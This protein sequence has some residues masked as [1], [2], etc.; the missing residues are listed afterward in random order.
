[1]PPHRSTLPGEPFNIERVPWADLK[2]S[3]V[4]AWGWPDGK[5]QAE[6]MA[7]LGPTGSGKSLFAGTLLSERTKRSGAHCVMLATKP[8]D[9]T[10]KKLGWPIKRTWPPDY[11]EN[12][13]IYW[14]PAG[15]PG[16]GP[17]KQRA[18]IKKFLDELWRPDANIIVGFDEIAYI[19]DD[20]GLRRMVNRYWREARALGI[21]I[22]A[23]TQRPK[24]VSRHMHAEPVWS[25]AFRPDDEDDANR[26]A[27]IIGGRKTY[28]DVLMGLDRYEFLVIHRRNREAYISRVE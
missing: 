3:L 27:E 7:V 2:E 22:L 16:D 14:P 1:M 26:V 19:E 11:G 25:V 28:R 6:H 13:V 17:G 15:R 18:A 12:Q 9:S 24:N 4:D 21:T 5:W 10:L 20:L 23:T 8:A